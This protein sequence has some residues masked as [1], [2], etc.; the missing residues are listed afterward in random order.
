MLKTTNQPMCTC[1]CCSMEPKSHLRHP[2]DFPW[3]VHGSLDTLKQIVMSNLQAVW[4]MQGFINSHPDFVYSAS[5]ARCQI[6]HRHLTKLGGALVPFIPPGKVKVYV[7]QVLLSPRGA[8]PGVE[9][10]PLVTMERIICNYQLSE[11][12][13]AICQKLGTLIFTWSIH[14]NTKHIQY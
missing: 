11:Q 2:P 14:V 4:W 7:Q 1:I 13:V 8:V 9:L 6:R 12:H 5:R 10:S 3:P